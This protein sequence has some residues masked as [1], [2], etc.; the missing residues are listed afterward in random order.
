ML[1]T[2]SHSIRNVHTHPPEA[3]SCQSL[4]IFKLLREEPR[5]YGGWPPTKQLTTVQPN[6]FISVRPSVHIERDA[7]S[8][9][10]THSRLRM[11]ATLIILFAWRSPTVKRLISLFIKVLGSHRKLSWSRTNQSHEATTSRIPRPTCSLYNLCLDYYIP[12]I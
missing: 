3:N 4:L 11:G 5:E 8:R 10:V 1:G 12:S 7:W 9:K 6:N 2:S